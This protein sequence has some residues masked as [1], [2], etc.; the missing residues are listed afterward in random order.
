[1]IVIWRIDG[2]EGDIRPL[3]HVMNQS[4]SNMLVPYTPKKEVDISDNVFF[5]F[6]VGAENSLTVWN[7]NDARDDSCELSFCA[8]DPD[9]T[10]PECDYVSAGYCNHANVD[11]TEDNKVVG[12]LLIGCSDGSIT[13]F[14]L[15]KM[16]YETLFELNNNYQSD[17]SIVKY[18]TK[19]TISPHKHKDLHN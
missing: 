2:T 4:P 3:Q 1:M 7:Y 5:F 15:Q 14:D 13:I 9:P 19:D 6:S 16:V 11:P 10:L 8:I 17:G 12:S 18:Q